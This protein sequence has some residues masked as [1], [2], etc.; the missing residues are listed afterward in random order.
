MWCPYVTKNFNY[1]K[2]ILVTTIFGGL[3]VLSPQNYNRIPCFVEMKSKQQIIYLVYQ[4]KI[5]GFVLQS[6]YNSS[7]FSQ[8][9][10]LK[11]CPFAPKTLPFKQSQVTSPLSKN[12][13]N[14]KFKLTMFHDQS[15]S[16]SLI[17]PTPLTL[18]LLY[19]RFHLR[20]P[21]KMKKK[22]NESILYPFKHLF[23]LL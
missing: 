8:N 1:R 7:H 19:F 9:Y 5:Y 20:N 15:L 21:C 14:S 3:S 6:T 16:K 2:I 12:N 23:P 11:N 10:V 22:W 13:K 4:N 18:P 17:H